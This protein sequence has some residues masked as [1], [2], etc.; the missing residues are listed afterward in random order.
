MNNKV[1]VIIPYFGVLPNY[2]N[3]W[4]RSAVYNKD[5]T[6]L[7]YTD[8]DDK[9]TQESYKNIIFYKI[10]FS[11]FTD[12][13]RKLFDFPISLES[14]YKLCD[15]R[16]TY[17]AALAKDLE[18]FDFWGHCDIDLIFGSLN[19]Y[20]TDTILNENDRIYNLGH[21]TLYRNNAEMNNLY[22]INHEFKDCFSYKY[23]YR[24]PFSTAY[25]EIGTK[26]GYGLS[27]ICKRLGVKNHISLDFADIL[28][29]K[30][31]FELA[32]TNGEYVDYFLYDHGKLYGVN[33]KAKKEY[34]YVHLQKRKMYCDIADE[35]MYYIS[36]TH[37]RN[38]EIDALGDS[39]AAS[40]KKSF[41]KNIRKMKIESKVKKIKQGAMIHLLN[42]FFR[43]INVR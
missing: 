7:I 10:T 31:N 17:G 3:L 36:P 33:E 8:S 13:I 11:E 37:F 30:Y 22:K 29:D 34:I 39:E 5:F 19:D 16:P 42:K 32:Y 41:E 26:Y 27:V 21:F 28:P 4:L 35:D 9:V 38:N 25:D 40:S 20:I 15:Y 43:R 24:T 23:V 6:F 18:G 2:F 12:R 14:P 1:A